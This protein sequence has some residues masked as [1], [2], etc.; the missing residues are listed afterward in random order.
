MKTWTWIDEVYEVISILGGTA[1]LQEIYE[2]VEERQI[3]IKGKIGDSGKC[4]S[5]AKW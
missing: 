4:T 1:H 5:Q 3:K 2:K